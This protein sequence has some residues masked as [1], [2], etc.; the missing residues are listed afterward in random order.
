[1]KRHRMNRLNYFGL[2]GLFLFSLPSLADTPVPA[3]PTVNQDGYEIGV[4]IITAKRKGKF[5]V[6]KKLKPLSKDLRAL[7]FKKF[8]QRD[9]HKKVLRSSEQ[10]SLQFPSGKGD[11]QLLSIQAHGKQP[12]GKLGFTLAIDNLDFKT[13]VALPDGGTILVAGPK[14]NKETVLFSVTAREYSAAAA[15]AET[16]AAKAAKPK[17]PKT[18][19]SKR[20]ARK[21]RPKKN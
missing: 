16:A 18:P 1:M 19:K 9:M 21:K 14:H 11:P 4:R 6:D 2:I 12:N 10:V 8:R 5:K 15:Q 13:R 7:P 20:K 3:A 17:K